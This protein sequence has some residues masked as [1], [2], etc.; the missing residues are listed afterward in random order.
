[1][2]VTLPSDLVLDVM[3][4]ADPARSRETLARLDR[5]SAVDP[6]GQDF[7]AVMNAAQPTEAT[8]DPAMQ[9]TGGVS[10]PLTPGEANDPRTGAYRSFEKMMLQNMVETML[11]P[12]ESGVFGDKISGGVW[13]SMAAD[14]LSTAVADSGGIGLAKVVSAR[15]DS[16]HM[17]RAGQWPY[18]GVS[19]IQGFAPSLMN[20]E[21]S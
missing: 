1:M 19:Q 4:N 7:I 2:A 21:Q 12:A 13:R 8:L 9:M 17:A 20:T 6:E 10:L 14:A 15:E 18:F 3:R 5:G 11:P 16:S